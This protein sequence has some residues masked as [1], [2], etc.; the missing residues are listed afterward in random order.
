MKIENDRSSTAAMLSMIVLAYN[1]IL[2]FI[3][4]PLSDLS[5]V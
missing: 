3:V 5:K 2:I 4:I 1:A